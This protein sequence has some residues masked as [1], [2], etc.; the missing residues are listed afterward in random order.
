M[1]D[2]ARFVFQDQHGG[3]QS[4]D[5]KDLVAN[6]P[7]AEGTS[8]TV[9]Y[10]ERDEA[11][12]AGLPKV[13]MAKAQ[14][15]PAVTRPDET[16]G[17]ETHIIISTGSGTGK[18]VEFFE[19]AVQPV[20]STLFP[21]SHASF[22][23]HTTE[24]ESSILGLTNDIFFPKANAGTLIRIILISGDGGVID[25]VNG[26]LAKSASPQY[27]PPE[28]VLLPLG[29][30][31][32]L[33]HSINAGRENTWGLCSLSTD[34][35]SRPLPIFTA[36]FSAGARLLV[37]EARKEE[38]LPQDSE[39]GKPTLH[40]AVVGSWGMHASLVA[41]SDT[42]E[43]RKFG[44]ERFKMAAK[45]ALF[46]ADGSPPHSYKGKVSVLQKG[47]WTPL[48]TQEHMYILATMV[49][50]LEKPFTISPAS[51]PLDGSMHLIHFG[52]TDGDETMR[53]MGLAY[54]G[55]KHVDEPSVLYEAID[56]LKIEFEGQE[57][58]VRWRRIC[59]DG[60]IIALESDGHVE[61][62]KESRH[63]LNIAGT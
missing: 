40:G 34:V 14:V 7:N 26:L 15:G 46:P 12:D 49:S 41:D 21:A 22:Q 2:T 60:K 29:T 27:T 16:D 45:E 33:Y 6:V 1:S 43:Y 24:S 63:V 30:A 13:K 47:T 51:K 11:D 57:K 37:D 8:S 39:T 5:Q 36:T 25:L 56:G 42:A 31:N 20:L 4:I 3:Q 61:I 35:G 54:Q 55:G 59:I 53:L 48:K 23:I 38:E 9:I 58:D 19:Q 18:G 32:A 44:V 50:N 17:R 52:P 62:R 28:V 10:V